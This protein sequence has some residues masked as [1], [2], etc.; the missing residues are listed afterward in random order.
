MINI[1]KY[2]EKD[3][4][5]LRKIC[6][7][8]SS[9]PIK[10]KEQRQFLFLMY[11][12]Y[13]TEKEADNCFVAVNDNDE[14][15]GYIICSENFDEYKK[16]FDEQY[17]PEIKKLGLGCFLSAKGEMLLHSLFKKEYPAHLHID[18]TDECQ[19]QGVG[20]KLVDALCE[21]LK[22]KG[23]NG[24]MLSCGAANK[25]AIKFYKKNSFKLIRNILGSC[26]MAKKL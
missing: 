19:G 10:T 12:D 16:C 9:L 26:I 11:N 22:E 2:E 18:I 23:V 8:T 21:H 25:G 15:V 14:A 24:L 7:K 13:Y 4:E 20:T 6:I 3:K 17:L 5:K 1:R